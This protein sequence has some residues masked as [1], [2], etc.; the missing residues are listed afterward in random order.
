MH[1]WDLCIRQFPRNL[2]NSSV[3]IRPLQGGFGSKLCSFSRMMS[4]FQVMLAGEKNATAL[5]V[6]QHFAA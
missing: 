2:G 3:S 5:H 6:R 4:F 1:C